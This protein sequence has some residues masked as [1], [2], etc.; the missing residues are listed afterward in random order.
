MA[1]SLIRLDMRSPAFSP[2]S[3]GELYAAALEHYRPPVRRAW[4]RV[5]ARTPYLTALAKL[6]K[7]T[8]EDRNSTTAQ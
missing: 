7:I 3:T 4:E 6:G 5:E 8:P 1:L 2:A